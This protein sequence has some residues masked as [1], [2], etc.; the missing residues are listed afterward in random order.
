MG[1]VCILKAFLYFLIDDDVKKLVLKL[2]IAS[3]EP[4]SFGKWKMQTFL[5]TFPSTFEIHI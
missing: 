2:R 4:S 3:K 5:Q 1:A